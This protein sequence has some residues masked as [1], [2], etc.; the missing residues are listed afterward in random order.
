M[1]LKIYALMSNTG[2]HASQ[3]ESAQSLGVR[4]T[5]HDWLGG[6]ARAHTKLEDED[7]G[8]GKTGKWQGSSSR[9]GI[10]QVFQPCSV[11]IT[12]S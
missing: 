2:N 4:E 5:C 7:P 10:R 8:F 12:A 1:L 6:L 11:T 9:G 3:Q